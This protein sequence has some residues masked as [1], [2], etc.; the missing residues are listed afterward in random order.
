[1]LISCTAPNYRERKK[2]V[3]R[4]IRREKGNEKKVVKLTLGESAN[5]A[6][7]KY[8]VREEDKIKLDEF[9][10]AIDGFKGTLTIIGH[11]DTKGSYEYNEGLSLRRARAVRDYIAT[12]LDLFDYTVKVS[13]RGEY[14]NLVEERNKNDRAKNRRVELTFI[15]GEDS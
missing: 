11:T 7:D 3:I 6:F 5:F 4:P 13:G 12:R 10:D 2:I 1:M 8:K 9:I 15:E 14:E